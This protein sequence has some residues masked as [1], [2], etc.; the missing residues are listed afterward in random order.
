MPRHY[1]WASQGS[2][3]GSKP[4]SQ[5]R[6]M[7]KIQPYVWVPKSFQVF[8]RAADRLESTS[9]WR[10]GRVIFSSVFLSF[11]FCFQQTPLT[12]CSHD[13][14]LLHVNCTY[15][16]FLLFTLSPAFFG[17][18][19][20]TQTAD[21]PP[22]IKKCPSSLIH[23]VPKHTALKSSKVWVQRICSCFLWF[24]WVLSS[25]TSLLL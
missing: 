3:H 8:W 23:I 4:A 5:G 21:F 15:S 1:W 22:F 13:L 7:L 9:S 6:V 16:F 12:S 17:L 11:C 19:L 2:C 24:I 10:E 18:I 25:I 14:L 20:V